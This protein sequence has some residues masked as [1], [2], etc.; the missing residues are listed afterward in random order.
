VRKTRMS[1]IKNDIFGE[2]GIQN[3]IPDLKQK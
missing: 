2:V 1:R 3:L